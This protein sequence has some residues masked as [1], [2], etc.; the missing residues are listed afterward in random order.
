MD[1]FE[2]IDQVT[3]TLR[4]TLNHMVSE[5]ELMTCEVVGVLEIIKHE[6]INNAYEQ[7]N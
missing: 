3:D 5:Y 7:E 6:T 1:R 2:R 4:K